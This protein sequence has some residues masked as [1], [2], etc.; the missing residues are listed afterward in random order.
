MNTLDPV[1]EQHATRTQSHLYL[2]SCPP[3]WLLIPP[4]IL[5]TDAFLFCSGEHICVA[6]NKSFETRDHFITR[7]ILFPP[8]RRPP[9]ALPSAIIIAEMLQAVFQSTRR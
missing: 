9:D 3:R 6:I 7:W 4:V 2:T 5:N 8:L 1:I